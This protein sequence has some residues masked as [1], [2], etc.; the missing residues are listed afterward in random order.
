MTLQDKYPTLEQSKRIAELLGEGAPDY[1]EYKQGAYWNGNEGVNNFHLRNYPVMLDSLIRC[2]GSERCYPSY[3]LA[4]LGEM[5]MNHW[6]DTRSNLQHPAMLTE[7]YR[8]RKLWNVNAM[9]GESFPTEAQARAALLIHLL[10]TN[11]K[12]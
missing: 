9:N 2:D 7:Y 12:E 4:E 3:D 5:I 1:H 6:D 8:T 11:I 10:S